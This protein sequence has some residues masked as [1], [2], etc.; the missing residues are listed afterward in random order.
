MRCE[1]PSDNEKGKESQEHTSAREDRRLRVL[2]LALLVI[3]AIGVTRVFVYRPLAVETSS[4]AR[5]RGDDGARRARWG[6]DTLALDREAQRLARALEGLRPR[7]VY[8]VIER[9]ENRLFV[10]RGG[11][12]LH[13]AICSTG[14]GF[15]LRDPESERSWVF[16]T[17]QG[18]FSVLRKVRDPIWKKPD[19]AFIEEGKPVPSRFTER[20]D[21]DTLGDY[22]LYFGNGYMI[23]GTLYERY[24]GRSITHGCVRLGDEDL[25]R[26]FE[27]VPE[28]AS[29]FI[30]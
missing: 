8:L 6:G 16:D 4:A 1:E 24:L 2:A 15:L 18:R 23:H 3:V 17:P 7:G 27:L 12:L 25:R 22:A 30:Y 20:L 13:E 29:I 14:S 9:S 11:E 5:E 28:G 10:W 21:Y 19:W 26:V